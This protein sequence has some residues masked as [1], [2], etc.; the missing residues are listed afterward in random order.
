VKRAITTQM[1][2][3]LAGSAYQASLPTAS[4]TEAKKDTEVLEEITVKGDWLG[5]PNKDNV[6][7]YPGGRS[8]VTNTELQQSGSRALEDALR[9]M[10]GVR[11]QD[12]TGTG[13]LPNIGIRGLDPRRSTRTLAL[14]DSIDVARGGAAVR[15]GPNNVGGVI[16]FI[17]KPIQ[18]KFS[19]TLREALTISTETGNVLTDSYLRAGA[20]DRLGRSGLS[21]RRIKKSVKLFEFRHVPLSA[22][23][24]RIGSGR[25]SIL[26]KSCS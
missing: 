7:T 2:I 1:T 26:I 8:A 19:A 9:L 14:V 25:F 23:Q 17:S 12:E 10:P 6:K 4:A 11:A 21:D 22:R 13:I 16:N 3:T 18:D 15:Y 24:G 20:I 5:V